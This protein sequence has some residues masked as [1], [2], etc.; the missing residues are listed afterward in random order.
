MCVCLVCV[1]RERDDEESAHGT[2]A[3]DWSACEGTRDVCDIM[4]RHAKTKSLRL[5]MR[6]ILSERC[7]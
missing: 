7:P 4:L 1:E 2:A 3:R 6:V 5:A